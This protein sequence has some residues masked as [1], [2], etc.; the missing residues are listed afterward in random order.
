MIIGG[1]YR[2][3]TRAE[4]QAHEDHLTT[5]NTFTEQM[6]NAARESKLMIVLGDANLCAQKW[7]EESGL[8]D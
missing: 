6:E 3:W 4:E 2:E 1:F 5:L 8:R 7:N